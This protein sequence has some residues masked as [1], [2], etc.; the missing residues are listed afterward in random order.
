MKLGQSAEQIRTRG[1][2]LG[3]HLISKVC[4]F[5]QSQELHF[6]FSVNRAPAK[7]E[8]I[9]LR[10]VARPTLN[11]TR[12]PVLP[13]PT[14]DIAVRIEDAY[15]RNI[16]GGKALLPSRLSQQRFRPEDRSS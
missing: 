10:V 8:R 6:H 3:Q 14:D 7:F 9:E 5:A 4:C 13:Y 15:R 2:E 11:G 1:S 12:P 16:D